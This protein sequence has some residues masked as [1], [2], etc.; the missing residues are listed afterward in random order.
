MRKRQPSP[1]LLAEKERTR[2]APPQSVTH[3]LGLGDNVFQIWREEN[4]FSLRQLARRS[5]IDSE[6]LLSFE[7]GP[8]QP[9]ADELVRLAKALRVTTDLLKPQIADADDGDA[10]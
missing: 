7:F 1:W 4:C 3:R 2:T 8:I 9:D 5:G 6:R 10:S